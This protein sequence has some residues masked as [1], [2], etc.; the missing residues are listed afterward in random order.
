MSVLNRLGR[1]FL[2]CARECG[3][4]ERFSPEGRGGG[5]TPEQARLAGWVEVRPGS[6]ECPLCTHAGTTDSP[7][8]S[9]ADLEPVPEGELGN[10]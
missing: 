10:P 2:V 4:E 3:R 5:L 9:D 7:A 6:W 8:W 1:T